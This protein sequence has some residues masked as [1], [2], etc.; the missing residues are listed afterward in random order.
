MY[1]LFSPPVDIC[2]EFEVEKIELI[3]GQKCSFHYVPCASIF[4]LVS[5]TC[6]L[7]LQTKESQIQYPYSINESEASTGS[8][9][10]LSANQS[11]NI[12]TNTGVVIY[13]AHVNLELLENSEIQ[14]E[15]SE[16]R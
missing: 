1:L 12:T 7:S 14:L 3:S 5:G 2:A 16:V 8:I 9:F 10:F 4:I 13:R 15:K 6:S 11:A